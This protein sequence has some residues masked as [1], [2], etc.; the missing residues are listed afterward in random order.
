MHETLLLLGQLN[1]LLNKILSYILE[2][3]LLLQ[4]G[5]VQKAHQQ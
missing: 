3:M 2:Y 5:E 1:T 4:K